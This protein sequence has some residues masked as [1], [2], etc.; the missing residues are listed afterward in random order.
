MSTYALL[1]D[2]DGDS[3]GIKMGEKGERLKGELL[4]DPFPFFPLPLF[5]QAFLASLPYFLKISVLVIFMN[6]KALPGSL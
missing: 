6:L 2:A 3:E 1:N 4:P 5:P